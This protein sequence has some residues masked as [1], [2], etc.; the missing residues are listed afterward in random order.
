MQ[1]ACHIGHSTESALIKVKSA[2]HSALDKWE[3]VCLVLLDLSAAFNTVNHTILLNHLAENF[4]VT[5]TGLAWIISYFTGQTQGVV[6]GNAKSQPI[7][8]SS[9]V[10][11]GSALGPI[12]FTIYIWPLGSICRKHGITYHLYA[13]DQQIYLQIIP[14]RKPW[15][16]P[17]PTWILHCRH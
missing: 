7:S 15:R 1:S 3:V 10:P 4:G 6:V 16:V 11:Q 9:G 17:C 14:T 13:D 5:S 2:I 8:L 12:M